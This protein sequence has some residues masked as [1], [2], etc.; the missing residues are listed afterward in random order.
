[1]DYSSKIY[2]ILVRETHTTYE[3]VSGRQGWV[4]KQKKV[5]IPLHGKMTAD[6]F[7]VQSWRM[8]FDSKDFDGRLGKRVILLK[9]NLVDIYGCTEEECEIIIVKYRWY[10]DG[11]FS[12]PV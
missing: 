3:G 7:N 6:G 2:D 11:L 12:E 5:V 8:V 1:M 4:S 10:V 9:R